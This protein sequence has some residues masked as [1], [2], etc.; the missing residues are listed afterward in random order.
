MPL[1]IIRDDITRVKADAIVNT[2]D[3]YPVYGRGTDY[4]VYQAAGEKKL[5]A[6]RRKLGCIAPGQAAVTPGFRLPAKYIIHTACCAWVDGKQGECETLRSCYDRCL[7]EAQ[8]LRLESIAFPLLA[9]GS[10][11]F[12]R[13][14]ALRIAL[15][16]F[17]H[18]LEKEEM[19]IYLVVFDNQSV[20]VAERLHLEIEQFIDEHYAARKGKL[21][22]GEN[23]APDTAPTQTSAPMPDFASAPNPAPR[24]DSAPAQMS[25]PLPDFAPQTGMPPAQT[26]PPLPMSSPRLRNITLEKKPPKRSLAEAIRLVGE[27]FQERLL[28][29]IDE[30]QLSDV[31]VYKR[32]NLDRKLFS[33]IRCNPHYKPGKATVLALSIAL[34]LNLDETKDLLGRAE[35]ALSPSNLSDLII[36]YFISNEIYDIYVINAALFQ[37]GQPLL[38]Q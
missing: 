34:K 7:Q 20:Q 4:A 16:S 21:E 35:L 37:Y 22:Y 11:N 8:K 6:S 9:A 33:K 32:A 25:A 15:D 1:Q 28:R 3:P 30:R 5:L 17:R 10:L 29:L 2:A 19:L 13:Q 24:K 12:P 14:E 36:E 26:P 23:F 38:G 31:E 27:T 18:F